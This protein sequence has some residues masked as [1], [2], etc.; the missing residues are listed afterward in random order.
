LF[1]QL[2]ERPR[3]DTQMIA[4]WLPI[5]KPIPVQFRNL[6]PRHVSCLFVRKRE[7]FRDEKRRAEAK[8]F[9]DRAQR[10]SS[11]DATES[12]KVRTSSCRHWLQ[13]WQLRCQATANRR[14]TEPQEDGGFIA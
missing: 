11:A 8:P 4:M 1:A 12:S 7:T 13:R 14:S 9:Q 6:L 2:I 3:R 10:P 5:S